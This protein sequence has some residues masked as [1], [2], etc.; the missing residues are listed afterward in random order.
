[1]SLTLEPSLTPALGQ[2][3]PLQAFKA[4]SISAMT[5]IRASTIDGKGEVNESSEVGEAGVEKIR[6]CA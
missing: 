4:L 6:L 1:M 5:F 2:G 3:P